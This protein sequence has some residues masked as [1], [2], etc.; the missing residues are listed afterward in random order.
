MSDHEEIQNSVAAWVLGA[1][2]PDEADKIARHIKGCDSCRAAAAHFRTVVHT[3]PLAVEEVEPPRRLRQRI[4]AAAAASAPSA[5]VAIPIRLPVRGRTRRNQ[6]ERFRL[7]GRV[8][9]SAAAAMVA[10]ALVGGLAIGDVASRSGPAPQPSQVARFTLAGH[11]S[12]AGARASVIDLKSDGITF[13]DFRGLP[14]L[15]PGKVYELWLIG[16]ANRVDAAGVFIPD[17]N[18]DKVVVVN[19]PL[20]G[21]TTMAVTT[22]QGPDGV[23]AP[24]QQPQLAGSLA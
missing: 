8:P 22:E 10:I 3:I 14:A 5:A 15:A 7:V 16:G 23:A 9:M 24:T 21:Y 4:L 13:V 17:G 19:R 11:D 6:W 18:G 12:M 2:D 1:S 20:V